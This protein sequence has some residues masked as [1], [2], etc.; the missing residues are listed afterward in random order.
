MRNCSQKVSMS[1][2]VLGCAISAHAGTKR[3]IKEQVEVHTRKIAA[4]IRYEFSRTV[5]TGR[6]IK[7][8]AGQEGVV[9]TTLKVV[10]K[11]GRPV[12]S[13]VVSVDRKEPVPT[14][15]LMSRAGYVTSRGSFTRSRIMTMKA[16]AYDPSPATIGRHAT[17]RTCTGMRAA[18]GVAA[19]DPRVIPLGSLLYVEGYGFA[20]ASDRGSAIKGNR[21][22]LCYNSKRVADRYGYKVVRVH[23]LQN[24]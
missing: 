22:D 15:F 2:A 1:L 7:A 9:T 21:I 17:G 13:E 16:T 10:Y 11:D 19:V 5:S 24:R 4:P 23:V 18:F 6:L 12:K 14:L 3:E 8:Q 20:I